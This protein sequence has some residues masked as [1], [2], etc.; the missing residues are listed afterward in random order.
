MIPKP[1]SRMSEFVLSTIMFL[2]IFSLVQCPG[3][4]VQPPTH[5][6]KKQNK[7]KKREKKSR[8]APNLWWWIYDLDDNGKASPT[9]GNKKPKPKEK[10]WRKSET[11]R[12]DL[13]A[14]VLSG[15]IDW[16]M[17]WT[18]GSVYWKSSVRQAQY[19]DYLRWNGLGGM[20]GVLVLVL[21][22][23]V[24]VL[25]SLYNFAIVAFLSFFFSSLFVCW[26]LMYMSGD[27]ISF[28]FMVLSWSWRVKSL[29]LW[30]IHTLLTD[31]DLSAFV[32]IVR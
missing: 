4:L 24:I 9:H 25:W 27:F 12:F 11:I 22:Y 17:I 29:Y 30:T 21:L 1:D 15:W 20:D 31:L 3:V 6:K 13:V 32:G 8:N 19:R 7:K 14:V 5:S 23:T 28:N 18:C 10:Q 26:V 2:F 16:H